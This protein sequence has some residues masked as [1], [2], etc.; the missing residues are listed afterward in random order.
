LFPFSVISFARLF[1]QID[2]Y[3]PF[4]CIYRPIHT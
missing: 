3:A 1:L 2:V 4:F